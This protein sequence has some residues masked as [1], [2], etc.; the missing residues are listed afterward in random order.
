MQNL[1]PVIFYCLGSAL[2]IMEVF[3]PGFGVPGISGI[4]LLT[5]ATMMISSVIGVGNAILILVGVIL[6]LSLI[7][8]ILLRSATRGKFGSKRLFLN[9]S[10]EV[11]KRENSLE[12]GTAGKAITA[13]RPAGKAQFDNLKADVV[14]EGDFLDSGTTVKVIR[15]E[16]NRIVVAGV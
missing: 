12:V 14:T 9:A 6:V 8:F 1:I 16:G 4:L 13:L 5:I 10:D 15:I 11:H 3:L 2:V 7:A